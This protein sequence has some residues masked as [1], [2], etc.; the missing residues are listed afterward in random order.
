[1]EGMGEGRSFMAQD[2]NALPSAARSRCALQHP[3][4]AGTGTAALT[5]AGLVGESCSLG[6]QRARGCGGIS[7][8]TDP[9]RCLTF[10]FCLSRNGHRREEPGTRLTAPGARGEA[11][12]RG[13]CVWLPST[14][15]AF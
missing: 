4:A 6:K 1:M 12:L 15:G 7:P 10:V 3:F 8:G 11:V 2:G 9:A 13:L 5:S 14:R